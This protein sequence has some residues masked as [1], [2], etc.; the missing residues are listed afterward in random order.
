MTTANNVGGYAK[1]LAIL[2]DLPLWLLIGIALAAGIF[3]YFPNLSGAMP[4]SQRQLIVFVT[5]LFAILAICRFCDILVS[6]FIGYRTHLKTHKKFHLTPVVEQ[7]FISAAK[8]PDGTIVT[9]VSA[10]L[11]AKNLTDRPLYLPSARLIK[12]KIS[13]EHIQ[14]MLLIKAPQSRMYGTVSISKHAIPAITDDEGNEQRV[15]LP[16]RVMNL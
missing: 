9:Q 1:T 8:Q 16:L 3:I 14:T 10:H 13:G 2:K 6:Y 7:S 15:K 12:P 5:V 11:L 4:Q